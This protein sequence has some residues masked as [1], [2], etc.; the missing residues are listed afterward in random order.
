MM[1]CEQD[2]AV[3]GFEAGMGPGDKEY[4]QHVGKDKKDSPLEPLGRNRVLPTP[5]C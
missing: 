2:L 4:G 5:W 1:L 3:A